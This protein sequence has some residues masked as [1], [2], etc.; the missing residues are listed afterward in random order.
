M[1]YF[2]TN[3]WAL[4]EITCLPAVSPVMVIAASVQVPVFTTS[5]QAPCAFLL[6]SFK[7][8]VR[9]VW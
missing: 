9:S 5:A 7:E 4:T 8:T 6:F 1:L 3:S 2:K